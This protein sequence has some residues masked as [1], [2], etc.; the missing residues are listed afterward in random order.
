M[1]TQNTKRSQQLNAELAKS[2][3]LSIVE[4]KLRASFQPVPELFTKAI[5]FEFQLIKLAD[6]EINLAKQKQQAAIERLS[7]ISKQITVQSR[8]E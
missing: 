6:K 1:S 2:R 3:S 5:E 4:Q 7:K 8:G